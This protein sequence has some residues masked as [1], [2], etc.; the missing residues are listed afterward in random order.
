M[1]IRKHLH[2]N[3]SRPI[4]ERQSID[5]ITRYSA[6][7]GPKLVMLRA[8]RREIEPA[9]STL[10][11][12]QQ[13]MDDIGNTIRGYQG[14]SIGPSNARIYTLGSQTEPADMASLNSV[15]CALVSRA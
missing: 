3:L 11:A 10:R 1:N 6:I 12:S 8:I 13:A 5:S 4:S 2:H 15:G 7:T 14:A 9:I